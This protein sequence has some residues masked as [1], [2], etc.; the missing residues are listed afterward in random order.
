V[1]ALIIIVVL[2]A[3]MWL[4][5]IRPQRRKQ[6]EQQDLLSNLQVADEIVTAGGIYG[7]ISEVGDDEVTV[8]IAPGTHVRMAKRAVAGILT[9]DD[10]EEFE[11]EID[12]DE[13][14]LEDEADEK[15]LP[16]AEEAEEEE[17]KEPELDR[18]TAEQRG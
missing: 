1:G 12:E 14:E 8:E 18:S 4:L 13:D 10:E 11:E 7:T 3:L 5:L 6:Q 2:L 15:E 17:G 16:A 9:E